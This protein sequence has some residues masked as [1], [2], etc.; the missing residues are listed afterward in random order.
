MWQ[1]RDQ[2]P[3]TVSIP[4]VYVPLVF[5]RVRFAG[6]WGQAA[7]AVQKKVQQGGQQRQ[8]QSSWF[9]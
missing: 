5:P 3:E 9:T 2:S 8:E 6:E 4:S 7:K 1:R